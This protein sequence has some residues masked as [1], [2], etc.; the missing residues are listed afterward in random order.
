M[1]LQT[2]ASGD[3]K[4]YFRVRVDSSI[5]PYPRKPS[6]FILSPRNIHR[7]QTQSLT[8]DTDVTIIQILEPFYL[9]F[10]AHESPNAQM[11]FPH[12][13]VGKESSKVPVQ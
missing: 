5:H 11:T 12:V 10:E 7:T 4:S 6:L 9:V 2:A 3:G 8:G 1:V 13:P